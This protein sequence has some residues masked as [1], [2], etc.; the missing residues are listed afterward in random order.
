[1]PL[2]KSV[3]QEICWQKLRKGKYTGIFS[4]CHKICLSGNLLGEMGEVSAGRFS[5]CH[6]ICQS[7][8]VQAE[9]VEQSAGRFSDCHHI[10]QLGK[11]LVEFG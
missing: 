9:M 4:A 6:H 3:C 5:D 11:L 7:G 10:C 1:M 8:N 2:I